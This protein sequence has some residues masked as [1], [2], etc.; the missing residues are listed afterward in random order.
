[1][2]PEIER[3]KECRTAYDARDQEEKI[4]IRLE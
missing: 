4:I 2:Q 1:M 3:D